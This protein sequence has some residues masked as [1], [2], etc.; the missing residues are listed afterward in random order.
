MSEQIQ[1]SIIATGAALFVGGCGILIEKRR[2]TPEG[3]YFAHYLSPFLLVGV[4]MFMFFTGL[5]LYE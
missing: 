5:Y 4:G 1:V 2:T 3:S